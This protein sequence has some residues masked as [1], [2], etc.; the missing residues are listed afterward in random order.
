[1]GKGFANYF[2]IKDAEQSTG[3][4]ETVIKSFENEILD[5]PGGVIMH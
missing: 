3:R 2:D 5:Y 1:M 4:D